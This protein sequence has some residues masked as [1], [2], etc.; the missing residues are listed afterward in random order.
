MWYESIQV[1]LPILSKN[2]REIKLRRKTNK[3]LMKY[4]D[5][6][7][8]NNKRNNALFDQ[9]LL[10][11]LNLPSKR[12]I[13]FSSSLIFSHSL[14]SVIEFDSSSYT[15]CYCRHISFYWVSTGCIY[16]DVIGQLLYWNSIQYNTYNFINSPTGNFTYFKTFSY[17]TSFDLI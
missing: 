15:F 10:F 8:I 12:K 13:F 2:K 9:V 7:R 11:N 3:Y 17:T 5:N 16:M 6:V 14:E 1:L 4:Q